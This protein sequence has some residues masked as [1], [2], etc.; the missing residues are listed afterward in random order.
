MRFFWTLLV[1]AQKM[2]EKII[3][4]P[5]NSKNVATEDEGVMKNKEKPNMMVK[6]CKTV[7]RRW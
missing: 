6:Q 1:Y 5:E 3:Q 4:E 7:R 2:R